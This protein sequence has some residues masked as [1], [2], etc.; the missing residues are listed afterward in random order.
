M[1][2]VAMPFA[3]AC[4]QAAFHLPPA[5]NRFLDSATYRGTPFK[6][7]PSDRPESQLGG[8][9]IHKRLIRETET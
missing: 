4:A 9:A 6:K 5:G 3:K 7:C 1:A 8:Q 2:M